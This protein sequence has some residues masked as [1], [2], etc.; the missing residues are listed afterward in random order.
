M[1]TY[2]KREPTGWLIHITANVWIF[3]LLRSI[4]NRSHTPIFSLLG[5]E[6]EYESLRP[7]LYSLQLDLNLH[8]G[9]GPLVMWLPSQHLEWCLIW[10]LAQDA[11]MAWNIQLPMVHRVT[12]PVEELS[13][14]QKIVALRDQRKERQL[15][16][17]KVT[18]IGNTTY[19]EEMVRTR[20]VIDAPCQAVSR[21][22]QQ[23]N[24]TS[25]T[26]MQQQGQAQPLRNIF[27]PR[28]QLEGMKILEL[29]SN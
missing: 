2:E 18:S 16:A 19:L 20:I 8:G 21:T 26:Q 15:P 6:E 3:D 23:G 29:R 12:S 28:A 14:R 27:F 4:R 11:S 1:G 24:E 10:E 9:R 25:F 17:I 7:T 5:F 13:M 22:E